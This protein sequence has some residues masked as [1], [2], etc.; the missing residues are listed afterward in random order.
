MILQIMV[1]LFLPCGPQIVRFG[2]KGYLA[3]PIL[4][5]FWDI[6]VLYN[7]DWS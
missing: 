7:P 3:S 2:G 6:I 4:V 1:S 5:N